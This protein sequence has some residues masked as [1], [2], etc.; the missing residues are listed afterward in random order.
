[1]AGYFNVPTIGQTLSNS[2]P[3]IQTN[4]QTID[5]SFSYDHSAF[6]TAVP[7][8][9]IKV[10]L[11]RQAAAPVQSG[12]NV[13][14]GSKA[15]TFSGET[16]LFYA[17]Q[18]GTAAPL[19]AKV[20]N[21]TEAGFSSTGWTRLPSG[22]LVKWANN[23][24][25]GGASVSYNTFAI[26]GGPNFNTIYTVYVTASDNTATFG[27]N[28]LLQLVANP[29]ITVY[30]ANGLVPPVNTRVSYLILGV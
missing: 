27:S 9:H 12:T 6:A 30:T 25:I 2:R 7:G 3:Q 1:M 20:F 22:I 17:R 18:I 24:A 8:Q 15:G 16:E 5:S 11:P 14:L 4:F 29:N 10:T 21:F 28:V 13:I 19:G 23:L 26:S